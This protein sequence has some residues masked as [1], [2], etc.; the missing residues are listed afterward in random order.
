MKETIYIFSN[1]KLKRK[2]NTIFFENSEGKRKFIPI[3]NTK[4]IFLFG[5]IELNSKLLNLLSQKEIIIH[6]FN[7]YNYYSGSF[8]PREHYN[9]GFMILNQARFYD[10]YHKRLFLAKK[11]VEGA[12][13]NGIKVFKYYQRR[14][15]D[16][17]DEIEFMSDSLKHLF[18]SED[19]E[20]TMQIEGK[21]KEVYFKGFNKII[22]KEEFK[23]NGRTRRPPEDYLNTLI[24]FVNSLIYTY[25]LSEIY[26]THLDPRI[27]F[28]H[29]TNFRRFS[30]NLDVAEIFKVV[31]GDRLIFS[32]INKNEI[33]KS[34]FEKFFGGI[35][36]NDRGKRKVLEKMEERLKQTVRYKRLRKNVSYRR[37]M[38][39]EL[40]KL[41]KHIMGEEEYS[42]FVM[43][44]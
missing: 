40:Y 30:L 27:G 2:D 24:S 9:S 5:E 11:F 7:Y 3:E 25:V 12:I 28:L 43:E 29:A 14:G 35:S 41:E 32:L 37:L 33:K 39:L 4:E 36:L 17:E 21:S 26:Q 13:K 23:F 44:W 10:D 16:L 18:E 6:Y 1:G 42:P 31:V 8:Y 15:R 19:I 38:R 22:D 20:S 34:D